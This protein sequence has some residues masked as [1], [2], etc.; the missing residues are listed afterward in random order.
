MLR[1]STGTT[2]GQK[3]KLK[4]NS[5]ELSFDF[6][7]SGKRGGVERPKSS[8]STANLQATYDY[9]PGILASGFEVREEMAG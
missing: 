3:P 7:P 6:C 4:R 9:P 2:L 5:A 1:H 8:P